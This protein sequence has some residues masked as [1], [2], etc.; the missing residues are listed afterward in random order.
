MRICFVGHSAS[1]LT[2]S[3]TGGSERQT[4]LLARE[5]A[6]RG[7]DVRLVVIGL[8]GADRVVDGV[9]VV[10]GW[11][12]DRGIRW[13]RAFTHRYPRLFALL[14][15]QEAEVYYTRGGAFYT[16]V[17]VW[18]AK[19]AH[20]TSIV[21]IASDGDLAARS[22]RVLFFL[23]SHR[24]SR[25]LGPVLHAAFRRYALKLATWVAVQNREQETLCRRLGL[26]NALIPNIVV[27]PP[28][29]VANVKAERDVVW[30]GNVWDGRRSK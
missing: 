9:R 1:G 4:A 27:A 3:A 12:P 14:R 7:H 17:A 29:D 16:F 10:P 28:C 18:A 6:A 23:G 26:D 22:G 24:L 20:A 5:L 25:I 13:L 21:A 15:A 8:G 30:V 11:D 2:Q 19:T